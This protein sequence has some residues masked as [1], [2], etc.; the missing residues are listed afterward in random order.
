[1]SSSRHSIYI[2]DHLRPA[3]D[4]EG[5]DESLSGRLATIL[6][7][8]L[9]IVRRQCPRL[10]RAEWMVIL[11]VCNGTMF[12]SGVPGET[13]LAG[14]RGATVAP[15]GRIHG[16]ATTTLALEVADGCDY[17]STHA[18]WGLDRGQ[19]DDLIARLGRLT[20]AEQVAV[21][22]RIERFWRRAELQTDAAVAQAW[23]ETQEDLDA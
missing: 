11:D 17:H 5:S 10:S 8:Y 7:R 1:M 21:I 14:L 3:I 23:I 12:G 16:E 2:P 6:D 15:D 19:A 22:E 9:Q 13:I 18:K 4:L 20:I